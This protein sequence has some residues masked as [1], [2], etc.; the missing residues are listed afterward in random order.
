MSTVQQLFN[1]KAGSWQQKYAADGPLRPRLDLFARHVLQSVPQGGCILDLG[2]G[3]GSLAGHLCAMGYAVTAYDIAE[4][5][6]EEGVKAYPSAPIAWRLL[7]PFWRHLPNESDTFDAIVASSVF[8]YIGSVK[9]GLAECQR[10]V[11]PGGSVIFTAPNPR[12]RV[13]RIEAVLR[14]AAAAALSVRMFN[15]FPRINGYLSYLNASRNRMSVEQWRQAAAEVGLTTGGEWL[16]EAD[17]TPLM[18]MHFVKRRA[19]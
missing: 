7:D 5:M 6:I 18:V 1:L 8:E 16:E 12:H 14:P 13:R 2:C 15:L 3:S 11:K 9:D 4:K 10:T 19:V 17:A